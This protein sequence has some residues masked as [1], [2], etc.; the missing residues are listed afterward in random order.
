[1]KKSVSIQNAQ[2]KLYN[3]KLEMPQ[4]TLRKAKKTQSSREIQLKPG[5]SNECA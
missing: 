3:V 5:Q 2:Q 1:M 4:L